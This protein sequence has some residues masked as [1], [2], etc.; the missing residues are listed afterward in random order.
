MQ[1]ET[2]IWT[3]LGAIVVAYGI[4]CIHNIYKGR[5]GLKVM[6]AFT[7]ALLISHTVDALTITIT[8]IA[9]SSSGCGFEAFMLTA[10]SIAEGLIQVM[11]SRFLI[12]IVA[13]LRYE[14]AYR[15]TWNRSGLILAVIY[16]F[17]LFLSIITNVFGGGQVEQISICFTSIYNIS[18]IFILI[19]SLIATGL[20]IM[21]Y[22]TSCT[23]IKRDYLFRPDYVVATSGSGDSKTSD[24]SVKKS[25]IKLLNEPV[26]SSYQMRE[27]RKM[28]KNLTMYLIPSVIR[29]IIAIT[30]VNM[31][32][33]SKL[34]LA[35]PFVLLLQSSIGI[36]VY[37]TSYSC[38]MRRHSISQIQPT[39][40][41]SAQP[42][43][44][45]QSFP[46]PDSGLVVKY[47]A[48]LKRNFIDTGNAPGSFSAEKLLF[49]EKGVELALRCEATFKLHISENIRFYDAVQKFKKLIKDG[50]HDVASHAATKIIDEFI[51]EKEDE[52]PF[53]ITVND[54]EVQTAVNIQGEMRDEIM[55]KFTGKVPTGDEFDTAIAQVY[56]MLNDRS[57]GAFLSR[58]INS[59]FFQ[60]FSRFI[61]G[62]VKALRATSDERR[63]EI[64]KEALCV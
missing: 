9:G 22:Y 62:K 14:T 46:L 44:E 30:I 57:S 47:D 39:D 12:N 60:E 4:L 63:H 41:V 10:N 34:G 18:S 58:F 52:S 48:N 3:A 59:Y 5:A 6:Q 24:N 13:S 33:S 50:Q 64:L 15:P 31:D 45:Q 51:Y 26:L 11:F 8:G 21:F 42:L 43:E 29:S 49:Y 36:A 40:Q 55:S 2:Y 16:V 56:K 17:S 1:T 19:V 32:P 53:A 27:L 37:G 7:I 23:F 35:F 28:R 20:Q 38:R 25:S 61:D 54:E